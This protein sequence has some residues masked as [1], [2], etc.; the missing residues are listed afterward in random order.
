MKALIIDSCI[1]GKNSRT[2]RIAEH[3]AR[4]LE[5]KYQIEW[6]RLNENPFLPLTPESM[7][8]RAKNIYTDH[9]DEYARQFAQSDLIVIAAPFWDMS[10]P[11][12]LKAFLERISISGITFRDEAAAT[13]GNCRAKKLIYVTTRGMNLEDDDPRQQAT[14][15][16]K[17]LCWLWGIP[18]VV[19]VSAIGMDYVTD[20]ERE[21]RIE[22]ACRLGT[23]ICEDIM[24]G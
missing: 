11:A 14:P 6:V 13:A 12:S 9:A 20:D 8:E 4:Q 23:R 7:Q 21:K 19:T 3:I 1:R 10:F 24:N 18:E 15:Y 5:A 2:L 17:A 22:E 16:I